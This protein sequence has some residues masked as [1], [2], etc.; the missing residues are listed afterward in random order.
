MFSLLTL[1][2]LEL[3]RRMF[4]Y[5][6]NCLVQYDPKTQK[7]KT[8]SNQWAL[9]SWYFAMLFGVGFSGGAISS[10]VVLMHDI[11]FGIN[12]TSPDPTAKVF[13]LGVLVL[14]TYACYTGWILVSYTERAFAGYN[15]HK[16]FQHQLE[17]VKS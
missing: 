17:K 5:V 10:S 8:A 2:P 12:S 6:W 9:K 1:E 7:Y 11:L 4:T 16:V 14:G 15:N 13:I 3:H